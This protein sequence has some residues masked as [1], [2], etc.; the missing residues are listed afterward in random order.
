[1]SPAEQYAVAAG[2]TL[3]IELPVY[4]A[5]AIGLEWA[6]WSRAV[7][8]AVGVNLV[9]HPLLY[10]VTLHR[11]PLILGVAEVVATAVEGALLAWW[12][13]A[14]QV[15]TVLVVAFVAN[16]LSLVVGSAILAAVVD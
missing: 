14:R 7:A 5:C 12:W 10:T 4:L 9:T 13:R 16:G 6:G 2:L 15:G 3:V 11:G 8:G 1:M